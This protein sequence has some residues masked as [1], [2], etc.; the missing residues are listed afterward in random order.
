MKAPPARQQHRPELSWACLHPLSLVLG[1]A[2]LQGELTAPS[3]SSSAPPNTEHV[4]CC[5]AAFVLL[6]RGSGQGGL[7][8][9]M[10]RNESWK[11]H[12]TLRNAMQWQRECCCCAQMLG[13]SKAL[14]NPCLCLRGAVLGS[15]DVGTVEVPG[16]VADSSGCNCTG[17]PKRQGVGFTGPDL[18][19]ASQGLLLYRK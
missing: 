8:M 3:R 15:Q 4:Q 14:L 7:V 10:Q 13:A 6:L 19:G 16:F 11:Q 18:P 9:F 17:M 12:R 5:G 1:A 2:A